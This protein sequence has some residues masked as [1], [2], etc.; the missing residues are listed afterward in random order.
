M[1]EVFHAP[2]GALWNNRGL[3]S[4]TIIRE[5]RMPLT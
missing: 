2:A 3:L 1:S 4:D 5:L